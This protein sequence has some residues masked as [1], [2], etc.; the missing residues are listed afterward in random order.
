MGETEAAVQTGEDIQ[1]A[2]IR[3]KHWSSTIG[4][5]RR[6]GSR[7]QRATAATWIC[8]RVTIVNTLW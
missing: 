4:F 5:D 8:I 2:T 6:M 3:D 1:A 7:Q